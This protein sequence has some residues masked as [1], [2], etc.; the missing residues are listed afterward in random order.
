[1]RLYTVG[2]MATLA[3]VLL[4]APLV[5]EA[6]PA[7]KVY[8]IG[9]MSIPSRESAESLLSVFAQ[10]LRARGLVEGE[11]LRIEWRWAEGQLERLPVFAQDLVQRQV[12]LIIA[13]QTD[14][15]LAA[16]RA[17]ATIPIVFLF[18]DDPVADG[19]VASL[20]RPG[21]NV[22]GLTYTPGLELA[23]KQLEFLKEYVPQV[24]R[25][26]VLWNPARYYPTRKLILS[27]LQAAAPSLGV[28][29]HVVEARGPEDFEPAFASM[30]RWQ[31]Q[32]LLVV[33]DSV[34][35]IHRRRL[36]ELEARH[37]LPGMHPERERVEAGSLM[38][39]GPSLADIM[40]RAAPYI[41]K[42]LRGAKPA[43]LPVEQPTK[44]ELVLNL[45]TAKALGLTL[46]PHLLYF[47]DEVLQ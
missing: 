13:P 20:A 21:G 38:A 39:Y 3:L 26:A 19:L 40:Q 36:A 14:S 43:E 41:E 32:A 4:V 24:S 34:F 42:I 11:N 22:T 45:K 33:T 30:V 9:Y 23:T 10:A 35:W 15:A 28:E 12:D 2:L 46:P 37:R 18:A 1:M 25:V 7:G 16:K 6:Q 31:A 27:H 17:T 5:A 29:L 8:R 47:A 44:F